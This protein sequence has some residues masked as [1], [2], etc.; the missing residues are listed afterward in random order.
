VVMLASTIQESN[1]KKPT[2]AYPSPGRRA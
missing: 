1:N 2:S